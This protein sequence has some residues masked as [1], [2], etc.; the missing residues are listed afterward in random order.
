MVYDCRMLILLTKESILALDR[1][2]KTCLLE[3]FAHV[4]IHALMCLSQVKHK[5]VRQSKTRLIGPN[6]PGIIRVSQPNSSRK[7][8]KSFDAASL[9]CAARSV[10]D[11]HH[12][13]THSQAWLYRYVMRIV[14]VNYHWL[15]CCFLWCVGIVSRSGTLTYE[16][17]W[18]TTNVGLGQT[19]C[20]GKC[21]SC[22][23]KFTNE[24]T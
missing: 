24:S 9:S 19:L 8:D 5:L 13:R 14:L 22:F 6:C 20:V 15:W 2:L 7:V 3:N 1:E 12:A 23:V 4:M 16:A 17:V 21:Y 11:W 10:Q 18:Q